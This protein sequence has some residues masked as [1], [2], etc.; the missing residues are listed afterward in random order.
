MA[1][2]RGRLPVVVML[3]IVSGGLEVTAFLALPAPRFRA[4][5][6]R[7]AMG[8]IGMSSIA[9]EPQQRRVQGLGR[10]VATPPSQSSDSQDS[11]DEMWEEA[12]ESGLHRK[13]PKEGEMLRLRAKTSQEWRAAGAA[14]RQK[15]PLL[16]LL[17]NR[18]FL[19]SLNHMN[20]DLRRYPQLEM[21][22]LE[23]ELVMVCRVAKWVPPSCS[24]FIAD[25]LYIVH[26]QVFGV[27]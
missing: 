26:L 5:H 22:L 21:G 7:A 4:P 16:H 24:L 9:D 11:V 2:Q 17:C 25:R 18:H 6:F 12:M 3:I 15:H 13:T 10:T 20:L 14:C 19:G 27:P 23:L 1:N 8:R